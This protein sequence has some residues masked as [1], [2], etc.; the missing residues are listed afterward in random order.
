MTEY[1]IKNISPLKEIF[2]TRWLMALAL[3]LAGTSLKGAEIGVAGQVT[4]TVKIAGL[5]VALNQIM[6]TPK[7]G[8]TH[9]LWNSFPYRNGIRD[10]GKAFALELAASDLAQGPGLEASPK[11]KKF[12]VDI[13]D[14]FEKDT[15]DAPRWDKVKFLG[16]FEVSLKNKKWVVTKRTGAK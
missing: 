10:A 1:K 13:V 7:E 12:K 11:S 15:Y 4:G 8:Y 16:R 5:E 2:M 3:C 6:V 9:V 14:F